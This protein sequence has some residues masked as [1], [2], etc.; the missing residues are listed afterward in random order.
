MGAKS[1]SVR[2]NP[3]PRSRVNS[4]DDDGS[5]FS[6]EISFVYWR[7]DNG[8]VGST[9]VFEVNLFCKNKE[10]YTMTPMDMFRC[11]VASAQA[12]IPVVTEPRRENMAGCKK[13]TV[14]FNPTVAGE[15]CITVAMNGHNV[16][17]EVYRR[18]YKPGPLDPL[19]TIGGQNE[20]FITKVDECQTIMMIPR[21]RFGNVIQ[22][23]NNSITVEIKRKTSKEMCIF[24]SNINSNFDSCEI[25]WKL[26][27]GG[28][29]FGSVLYNSS[30]LL[31]QF[32]VICLN[33]HA[34]IEVDRNVCSMTASY[35]AQLLS[36]KSKT[37]IITLT[38][39]VSH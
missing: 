12:S 26:H 13:T 9:A 38:P 20:I 32:E 10:P 24:E 37:V 3:S 31:K 7:P 16:G 4:I 18:I 14:S 15:Y 28:H 5:K 25:C 19:K 8:H 11:E 29:F 33:D 30:V 1:S 22:L 36:P 34:A 2:R 23:I 17:G 35:S 21:D 39:R 27:E 6:K